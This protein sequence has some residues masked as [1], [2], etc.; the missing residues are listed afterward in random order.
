MSDFKK[1]LRDDWQF[2]T[3][4]VTTAAVGINFLVSPNLLDDHSAYAFI[5]N[6]IDDAVFSV[7]ILIS[8]VL[9]SAFFVLNKKKFRS[10]FLV[11][12]QFVWMILFLAYSWRAFT[13]H[14]N[15]SWI[16]ALTINV[17]IFLIALWGDLD[18]K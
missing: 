5:V 4:A 13:G 16:M 3:V 8:G 1:R 9:G 15:S 12:Y 14:P 11:F 7:P 10:M 6:V 18:G 17:A 2:L